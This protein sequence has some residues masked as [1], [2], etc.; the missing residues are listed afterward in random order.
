[1]VTKSFKVCRNNGSGV[2]F[3]VWFYKIHKERKKITKNPRI[4]WSDK[5]KQKREPIKKNLKP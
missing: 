3:L 1:M 5:E 4:W 2:P